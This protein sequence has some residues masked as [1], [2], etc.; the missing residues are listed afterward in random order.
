MRPVDPRLLRYAGAARGFLLSTAALSVIGAALVIIQ[1]DVLARVISDAFLGHARLAALATPLA[2]LAVVVLGRSLLAWAIEAT[3]GRAAARVISQL[4]A[5]LVEHV[6]HRSPRAHGRSPS[7][8]ATL[9]TTGLDGL[10]G[11]FARYLPQL[12]IAAVVPAAV[13]VRILAADWPAAVLVALTVPLIPLFMILIGLYTRRD[14]RRQ[15]RTLSVLAHHFVDLVAGL[16]VLTAFGRAR[17]QAATIRRITER[18]RE[19]TMRTLRVAFLSSLV[20]ELLATLSVALV[21]VSVGLRLVTGHLDLYTA[22]VVLIL[23]PEVYLPLRAVGAR[24]HDSAQG[25]AA[26]EELF[27]VL[28]D[29]PDNPAGPDGLGEPEQ[30]GGSRAARVGAPDPSRVPLRLDE[31]TVQGRNGPVLDRFCASIEPGQVVGLVGPSGAGKSTLLDVLLGW[32]TPES[33]TVRVGGLELATLDPSSW[34]RRIALVG[35]QPCLVRGSVAD[36]IRIG[37]PDATDDQLRAAADA[38]ALDIELDKP[39]GELGAGLST[40]QQ[41]RVALARALLADRPLLLLDEPTEGLDTTTERAVL[42]ALPAMLAGRTAIIATHRPALLEL[43]DTVL[44]LPG[45]TDT[46]PTARRRAAHPGAGPAAPAS[47]AAA[48]TVAV[49]GADVTQADAPGGTGRW[50]WLAQVVRP[51]RG[52]LLAASA[53]GAGALGCGVALTATSA[54]LIATAALHPPVLTLMV[55]IVAVRTFGLAKGLLRYGERLASHDAA[56]RVLTEL[57]VRIWQALVRLGPAATARLRQGELLDRLVSDTATQQDVLIRGVVPAI[58]VAVVGTVT[59]VGL[60]MLLPAAGLAMAAGLMVAAGLGPAVALLAG[61]STQ[62]RAAPLRAELV[63]D[64]VEL[65][66]AAPDLVSFGAAAPRQR[67]LTDLD[68]RLAG[69]LRTTALTRAVGI[70]ITTFGVGASSLA[71]T[72]LG[73]HAL[74]AG[75][76]G[77]LLAVLA[78]TPLAVADLVTG[79]P[80]AAQRLRDA[81]QAAARLAE[82]DRAPATCREPDLPRPV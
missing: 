53:A 55:A 11:Y 72:V 17:A 41:R 66:R 12:L 78:L 24:F 6:L 26:A 65:M 71:C 16:A 23:A 5:A 44:T 13:T 3:A 49:T 56:L 7:E 77:P 42:A 51:Y 76:P 10:D 8:V 57:R 27:A 63:A 37:R 60:G 14:V 75:L 62:R 81:G 20:L 59:A 30:G 64:T 70:G 40:G 31:I 50:A 32:R 82:L 73:I 67:T 74:G 33:G 18:Y 36:N 28:A 46:T 19:H 48:S 45:T 35:Q 58:S 29:N 25:V 61:R 38:A 47:P 22:L 9:A 39:V 4:R 2:V 15:W 68:A 1:A 43:C 79:L 69:A 34:L 80:D 52:R 21:A 54:W